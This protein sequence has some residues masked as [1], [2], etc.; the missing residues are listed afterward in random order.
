VLIASKGIVTWCLLLTAVVPRRRL[1]FTGSV[2]SKEYAL[3]TLPP[4]LHV[5]ADTW[6]PLEGVR[7][8]TKSNWA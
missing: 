4:C 5:N 8:L 3:A 1:F 2:M 6:P 7:S